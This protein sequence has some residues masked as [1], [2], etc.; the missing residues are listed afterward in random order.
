MSELCAELC[1][2]S[3]FC[4][5]FFGRRANLN[6]SS[7]SLIFWDWGKV[8]FWWTASTVEGMRP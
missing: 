6:L 8:W 2:G 1:A 3:L 5:T 4:K 7:A